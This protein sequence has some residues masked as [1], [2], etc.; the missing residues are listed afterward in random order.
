MGGCYSR[1][2]REMMVPRP[3]MVVMERKELGDVLHVRGE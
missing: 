2:E 1:R 3:R